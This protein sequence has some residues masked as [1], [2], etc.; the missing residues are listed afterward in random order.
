MQRRL[1]QIVLSFVRLFDI[2]Q[3]FS[4]AWLNKSFFLAKQINI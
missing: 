4:D 3:I 2:L 1:Q